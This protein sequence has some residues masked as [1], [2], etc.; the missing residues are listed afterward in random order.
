MH[1]WL[2]RLTEPYVLFPLFAMLLLGVLWGTTLALI[3]NESAAA[4]DHAAESV[5]EL[6]E[7]YEAQMVR[8]LREI[9]LTLK[10]VKSA[11]EQAPGDGALRDVEAREL[12]PSNLLFAI[13]VADAHGDVVAS[14]V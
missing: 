12:L 2:N 5:N 1:R 7:T 14:T 13:S 10:L 4:R 9:D 6:V 8:A 11:Y 3:G